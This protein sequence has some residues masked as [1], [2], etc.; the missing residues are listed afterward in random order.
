MRRELHKSSR[1]S[2]FNMNVHYVL[3][4][5]SRYD[6]VNKAFSGPAQVFLEDISLELSITHTVSWSDMPIPQV[7]HCVLAGPK[8]WALRG[9][10]E[11]DV[12][13][14]I[15]RGNVTY[16]CSYHPQDAVDVRKIDELFTGVEDSEPDED[17]AGSAK[18]GATTQ[19]INY[20][21]WIQ[22]HTE[23]LIAPIQK[24][25]PFSMRMESLVNCGFPNSTYLYLDIETHPPTNTLQCITVGFDEGAVFSIT[26]YNYKG[27]LQPD[28][29]DSMVWLVRALKRY[30]VVIHNA[31]FDLPFLAMFHGLAHGD[32]IHDTMLIWHRMF[33][34]A[35][36]SLAHVIQALTNL[37]YHKDEAGTFCPHNHKQQQTLLV[38]NARDVYALREVH[39]MMLPLS[40][41]A[42]SVC[43]SIPDYLFTGLLGFYINDRR[44]AH[45]R[46]R[47]S[48]AAQQ[49][50]RIMR[51]LV[52]VSDFNPNSGK[53]VQIWL[54]D[55]LKYKPPTLTDSGAPATDATTLYKLLITHP[56]NV[57]LQVLL[58][59]KENSKRLSSINYKPY[60]QL[61][62]R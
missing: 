6:L 25:R 15:E 16:V 51:L 13:V 3:G 33:P 24:H 30:T 56:K 43:D 2:L 31:A 21:F 59:I 29:L 11:R 8:A 46:K 1:L 54:Y 49:L 61:N 14:V 60:T 22:I 26:I 52:G 42:Q 50:E 48:V 7:S 19:R 36:K 17:D 41:S 35:D 53:Q 45:H 55:K 62:E 9:F 27:E 58:E 10:T 47:L 39:K 18:D 44:L 38:Y 57:A 28:A 20:R 34:E 23:K 5:R 32:K 4:H 40:A 12:G 37:P